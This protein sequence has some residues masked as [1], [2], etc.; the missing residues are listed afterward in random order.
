MSLPSLIARDRDGE[1]LSVLLEWETGVCVGYQLASASEEEASR[2]I[3]FRTSKN[4]L[5][6]KQKKGWSESSIA[7]I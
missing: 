4:S 1:A 6:E 3:A 5:R 7:E 2:E